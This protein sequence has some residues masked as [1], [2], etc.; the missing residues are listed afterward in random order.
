MHRNKAQ[1]SV[2]LIEHHSVDPGFSYAVK[3]FVGE[4]FEH[5]GKR[6]PDELKDLDPMRPAYLLAQF[7]E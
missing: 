7:L 1:S 6:T 5:M 3:Q 4:V 2:S